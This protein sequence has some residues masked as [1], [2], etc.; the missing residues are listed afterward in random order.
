SVTVNAGLPDSGTSAVS[1]NPTTVIANGTDSSTVT[2]T[3]RD[4]GGN[5]VSGK[6][7]ALTQA[8]S[9]G[10]TSHST[11][12]P[13]SGSSDA[14]GV[15]TFTVKNTLTETI[16]YT[17]TDTT[18]S[19]TIGTAQVVFA[20]VDPSGSTVSSS[21]ASVTANGTS[22]S[23]ITVTLKDGLGSPAPGKSVSTA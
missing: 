4:V 8:L 10:G 1:A 16:T 21:P 14:G 20:A 13:A 7:V 18:D 11:I 12:T 17:A 9:G 3:L 22:T 5:P 19:L 2:V 6:T 23:T 15:V